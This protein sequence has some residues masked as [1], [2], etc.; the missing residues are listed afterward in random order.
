MT[1]V[2]IG[3][4]VGI[5]LTLV[6]ASPGGVRFSESPRQGTSWACYVRPVDSQLL[7]APLDKVL[8][9]LAQGLEQG[10]ETQSL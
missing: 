9:E 6:V 10:T 5:V 8:E 2:F 4:V 1:K 3:I 7:C